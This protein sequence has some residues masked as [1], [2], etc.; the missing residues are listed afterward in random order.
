MHRTQL[1][2]SLEAFLFGGALDKP[3]ASATHG[4]TARP[5]GSGARRTA[6]RWSRAP[7][8]QKW[9]G[10]ATLGGK[11]ASLGSFAKSRICQPLSQAY[12][13]RLSLLALRVAGFLS[14]ALLLSCALARRCLG[15]LGGA[16]QASPRTHIDCAREEPRWTLRRERFRARNGG[17]VFGDHERVMVELTP[18]DAQSWELP[19]FT[20]RSGESSPSGC[21]PLCLHSAPAGMNKC[22]SSAK[23]QLAPQAHPQL[24]IVCG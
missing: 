2:R 18:V 6:R 22:A 4:C 1:F 11:G 3:F 12:H 15:P 7:R 20:P 19:F 23:K 8:G 13:S 17:N 5:L 21:A 16:R 10:A 9:L 24:C 14:C